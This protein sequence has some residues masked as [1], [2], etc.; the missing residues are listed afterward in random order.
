[1]PLVESQYA[2]LAA[3]PT[4]R[5]ICHLML[6]LGL[7]EKSS[8]KATEGTSGRGSPKKPCPRGGPAAPTE[9]GVDHKMRHAET[10]KTITAKTERVPRLLLSTARSSPG[11]KAT[12]MKLC[13][14]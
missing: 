12:G 8:L 7:S 3:S 1:M 6:A 14:G 9:E 11:N 5:K 2:S 10:K 13:T 4:R